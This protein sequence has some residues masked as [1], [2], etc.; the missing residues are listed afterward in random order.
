MIFW[1]NFPPPPQAQF[2][3]E[4]TH[5]HVFELVNELQVEM[6]LIAPVWQHK[7]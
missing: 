5:V 7:F 4:I 3:L 1:N 2:A 6:G